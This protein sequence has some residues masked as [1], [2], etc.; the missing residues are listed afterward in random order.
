MP[1]LYAYQKITDAYTTYALQGDGIV[2]LCDLPDGRTL[3]S[4]PDG[5]EIVIPEKVAVASSSIT[6]DTKGGGTA[7]P[8]ENEEAPAEPEEIE[9]TDEIKGVLRAAAPLYQFINA[10]VAEK[11]RERYSLEDELQLLRR[12]DKDP[13]AVA[14]YDQFVEEC[15]AWG[16]DQKKELGL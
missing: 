6:G 7:V 10:R 15:V 2:E 12:R 11:I 5:I 14:R 3:V 1:V 13:E 8:E 4:V 9:V 16:T